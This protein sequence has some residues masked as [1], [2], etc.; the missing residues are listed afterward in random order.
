MDSKSVVQ[1]I[2]VLKIDSSGNLVKA[3]R[4]LSLSS[5]ILTLPVSPLI[6]YQP[7]PHSLLWWAQGIAPIPVLILG[8]APSQTQVPYL[9][10]TQSFPPWFEDFIY[11][12]ACFC[13]EGLIISLHIGKPRK[14]TLKACPIGFSCFVSYLRYY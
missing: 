11:M 8:L 2:F 14:K 1:W 3:M 4:L 9:L 6:P 12:F 7:P 5:I 13:G 10:P